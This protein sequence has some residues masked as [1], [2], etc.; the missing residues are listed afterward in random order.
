[1]SNNNLTTG[2]ARYGPNSD[3]N[4]H[5]HW[6]IDMTGIIQFSAS[7]KDNETLEFFTFSG[8]RYWGG[9]EWKAA[10]IFS[11]WPAAQWWAGPQCRFCIILSAEGWAGFLTHAGLKN[12]CGGFTHTQKELGLGR[13][14]RFIIKQRAP[15]QQGHAKGHHSGIGLGVLFYQFKNIEYPRTTCTM[16]E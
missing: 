12:K 7:L 13:G 15:V 5:S 11:L 9:S 2:N 3:P 1:V 8:E 4:D 6:E 16:Q 14:W 10:P